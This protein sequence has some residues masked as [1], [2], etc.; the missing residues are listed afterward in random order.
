MSK[1][2]SAAGE[3]SY[4]AFIS[5]RHKP[6]DKSAAIKIQKTIE[7]Y[8]VPKDLR[9]QAGGKK[10][11][12][13][14]RDED[15]LPTGSSLSDSIVYALD[16]SKYLIVICTPDL[17]LSKWCE[18][19]IR[20]F[21][22]THGR[23]HIIAVLADGEPNES[24][25]P[26]LLYKY[27]EDGNIIENVEPL[28]ANIGGPNHTIDNKHYK[29]E[30][31]RVLAALIGCPFDALWQRE[32]RARANR[33][34][35]ASIAAAVVMAAFIIVVVNKNSQIK[36][37]NKVISEQNGTLQERLSSSLVD[38]GFSYL[39]KYDIKEALKN[40][41][42]AVQEGEYADRYDRRAGLLLSRALNA[43]KYEE[44]SSRKLYEQDAEITEIIQSGDG[45]R[46]YFADALGT[47]KCTDP[48]SGKVLWEF[49][50]S[51]EY[52]TQLNL[53]DA[54]LFVLETKGLVLYKTKATLTAV[55]EKT[56]AISWKYEYAGG[57]S[58]NSFI[59]LSPDG[60]KIILMDE[61]PGMV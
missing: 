4:I 46:L 10:L 38:L 2:T 42:A 14:F 43:Y 20:Y 48:G 16:H 61:P 58:G 28:A 44:A 34:A 5:Y 30:S 54:Q 25:S 39:E 50:A 45:S 12:K 29:K 9:E 23:D 19:E 52:Q 32:R 27:D 1:E 17:P 60:S 33:I 3:P 40:G 8:T 53:N 31:V 15:E 21:L 7:R 13:V 35:K 11:G 49:S 22:Q 24:F 59:A 37:R 18:Q 51:Q 56:G 47:A 57:S 36:A 26:L 55:D 41:I 6:L